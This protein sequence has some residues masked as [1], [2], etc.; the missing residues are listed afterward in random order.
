ME[1][2][3][4]EELLIAANY[5]FQCRCDWSDA[6]QIRCW[7]ENAKDYLPFSLDI[8]DEEYIETAQEDGRWTRD[9][10]ELNYQDIFLMVNFDN[11]SDMIIDYC[12]NLF[13][14][15]LLLK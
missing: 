11:V 7:L 15:T 6:S 8:I 14:E 2:T 5:L 9:C 12:K 1:L 13:G 10:P 3:K 4:D